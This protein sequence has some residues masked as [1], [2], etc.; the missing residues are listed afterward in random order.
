MSNLSKAKQ[1]V[2]SQRLKQK[3][4]FERLFLGSTSVRRGC[5]REQTA[6]SEQTGKEESFYAEKGPVQRPRGRK[7]P[8]RYED[9]SGGCHGMTTHPKTLPYDNSTHS[10][11]QFSSLVRAHRG[12]LLLCHVPSV[13]MTQT[14]LKQ[15]LSFF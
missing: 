12:N 3:T 9:P 13:T 1:Q 8:G 7:E 14:E 11:A 4:S 5:G 15:P 6:M 2:T 10:L